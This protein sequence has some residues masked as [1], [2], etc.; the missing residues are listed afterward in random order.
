MAIGE[1]LDRRCLHNHM[2][3]SMQALKEHRFVSRHRSSENTS[4]AVFE[5]DVAHR[6]P[7]KSTS[8]SFVFID[9]ETYALPKGLVVEVCDFCRC[10]IAQ[11]D[12]F[13]SC[14]RCV[15]D[16]CDA[17]YARGARFKPGAAAQPLI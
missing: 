4:R 15:W 6:F 5:L 8:F 17:C 11:G 10:K 9:F 7:P 14:P 3:H 16:V 1:D 13:W 12:L 2:L